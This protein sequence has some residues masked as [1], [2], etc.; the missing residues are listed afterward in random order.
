MSRG[1]EPAAQ[2]RTWNLLSA[3]WSIAPA[4]L[5]YWLLTTSTGTLRRQLAA[6]QFWSL[7][8]C[9]LL[10]V[11]CLLLVA[12]DL[13]Q[14]L[15]RQEIAIAGFLAV[16]ALGLTLTLPPRTN[17]IYYDEQIY[18]SV[19][20]NLADLRLAQVCNDGSV[21]SGR[22]RCSSGEYNKQP[23]GY[24]HLLSVVYRFTGVRASTAPAVNA[25][26]MAATAV[27]LFLLVL[28]LFGD[29]LAALF[30]GLLFI[31]IPEQ[32]MWSAT[33]AV[34]PSASMAQVVALLLAAQFARSG[35]NRALMA[36]A[37]GTA[38]ALQFRPESLL[39]LPVVALVVWP[40]VIAARREPS[41]YAA[42]LLFFALSAIHV[43]HLAAVRDIGWG[44]SA[45]RF[46]LRFVA[47]NLRANG[48]F[49]LQDERFPFVYTALAILGVAIGI[50]QRERLAVALH[51]LLFFTIDL[52]FYAGSYDYGADVRYSLMT[53][54][55]LAVLGGLG[56]ASLV[57]VLPV[58]SAAV[59]VRVAVIV[60]LGVSLLRS[61]P[62]VRAMP[63]EA[64]AAREDVRF[65]ESVVGQLP[66]NSYVL[67]HN[68]GMFQ[69][70]GANAGQMS[71]VAD[72]PDY[73][74]VLAAR[75]TGGVYLHWNF[76][77]NVRDDV[78]AGYCRKVMAGITSEL[79]AERHVRDQ[80]F[81]FY[82]FNVPSS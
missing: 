37:V 43:A 41:L 32:L 73:A 8:I 81:A 76:W 82:R 27:A 28:I 68:P 7:E 22:L 2:A 14:R 21:E 29:R 45:E 57:R 59:P 38:Y 11:V 80:R 23:Y 30:A 13:R 5:V 3:A 20:Q 10:L 17:R 54:P 46:S 67:T 74:R 26:V 34:E 64:W 77:C 63:E 4:L 18:Q 31:T 61:A 62:L 66:P 12:R 48:W 44:T 79:A 9:F 39:I 75:F 25:G 50:R 52:V 71:R 56:L 78:Q 19:G 35:S 47:M 70:W 58:A 53:Y 69:V 65:A 42:L 51:F 60:L 1:T 49:F 24:P 72:N 55:S 40:R 16:L 15:G 36:T 6:L 33:A